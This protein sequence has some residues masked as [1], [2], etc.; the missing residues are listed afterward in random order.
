MTFLNQGAKRFSFN[1]I[2]NK[3]IWN[4]EDGKSTWI[5][6]GLLYFIKPLPLYSE[7]S[8]WRTHT[9]LKKLSV[10]KRCPLL[11]GSLPK[12]V[13][14]VTKHFFRCSRHVRYLGCPLLRGFTVHDT[15][16]FQRWKRRSVL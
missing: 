8:E 14:F 4:D 6:G 12:I 10:I 11:G 7:T 13:T 2:L 15:I 5:K 1:K 3:L 16:Y 9:G